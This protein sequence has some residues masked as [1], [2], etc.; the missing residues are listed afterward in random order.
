ML[1]SNDYLLL[2]VH[3]VNNNQSH[4]ALDYLNKGGALDGDNSEIKFLTGA[5]YAE[6]G[7][8]ER[9]LEAFE[10]TVALRPENVMARLQAA[11]LHSVVGSAERSLHHIDSIL[12]VSDGGDGFWYF[13]DA[14]KKLA[15]SDEDSA[16]RSVDEGLKLCQDKEIVQAMSNLR[17][18]VVNRFHG[19][20]RADSHSQVTKVAAE[21]PTFSYPSFEDV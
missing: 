5:I 2:A 3:A 18:N 1:S 6:M 7:L 15:E 20:I 12:S 8:H 13:A 9:A 19:E 21:P 17:D 14:L 4:I 16:V 11:I 10:S